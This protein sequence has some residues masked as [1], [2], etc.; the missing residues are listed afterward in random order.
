M[1]EEPGEIRE[2]RFYTEDMWRFAEKAPADTEGLGQAAFLAGE[3]M[4]DATLATEN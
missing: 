3:R 4:C 1:R 2:W